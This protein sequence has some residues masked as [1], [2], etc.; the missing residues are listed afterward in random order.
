MYTL[1][2]TVIYSITTLI[3]TFLSTLCITHNCT[4]QVLGGRSTYNFIKLAPTPQVSAL[5]G[6]V[7]AVNNACNGVAQYNP[8]LLT[9]ATINELQVSNNFM[10][11]G[12]KHVHANYTT[13][14][15]QGKVNIA[16]NYLN[17]GSIIST[18][19]QGNILGSFTPSDYYIQASYAK[20]YNA[21]WHYGASIKLIGSNYAQYS[22]YAASASFAANYN[23]TSNH[24]TFGIL[25]K[26]IGVQLKK[27]TTI[28][29]DVPFD[30]QLGISKKLAK[31]PIE[32]ILTIANTHQWNIT[33]ADAAFENE[34]DIETKTRNKILDNV[35]R[36]CTLAT[37]IDLNKY[38][39]F[40]VAYNYLRRKELTLFNIGNGLTG[41]S[42]GATIQLYAYCIQF[43]KAYYQNSK[44]YNQIGVSIQFSKLHF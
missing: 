16:A 10:Y 11:G 17:Y 26:N 44:A 7:V 34:Y 13:K 19:A 32:F 43:A 22:S 1:Y 20:Q 3:A 2:H 15:N 36:H 30:L 35:A 31:A 27:Y 42:A 39:Q 8:A 14:L 21:Y 37:I 25:I 28:R 4:A 12:I 18:N 9:H 38:I 40:T 6:G 5:G 24:I 33:Y 23:D 29:E 41:F